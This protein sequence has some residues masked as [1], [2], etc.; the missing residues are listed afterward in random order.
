MPL[1]AS[2]KQNQTAPHHA[3]SN[4]KNHANPTPSGRYETVHNAGMLDD[5]EAELVGTFQP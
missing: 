4:Q 2:A 5:F 1:I 3:K